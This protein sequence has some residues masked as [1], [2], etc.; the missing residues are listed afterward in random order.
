MSKRVSYSLLDP[1]LTM[2]LKRLY[3]TLSIPAAVP[4]EAIVA[5]GHLF[6]IAGA[7][8]FAYS[9]ETVWGGAVAACGVAG[10][11]TADV[12]DGTHARATNQCRHGGELLDHFVD[13]LSFAY[14]VAGLGASALQPSGA[15]LA[16]AGVVVIYATAVLTN[17]RAKMVGEFSLARFGPTEF[18]SLLIAFALWQAATCGSAGV[19]T[20]TLAW[21]AAVFMVGLIAAGGVTLA[22]SLA[23]AVREVNAKS[24]I[25]IDTTEWDQRGG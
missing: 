3:K 15:W 18:K 22:W 13:P 14:W 6:A 1:W 2:P 20:A 24:V 19:E 25:A 9:S 16:V 23:S 17:I 10:N 12:L 8:G 4:P 21:R 11:H 5:T 7:V